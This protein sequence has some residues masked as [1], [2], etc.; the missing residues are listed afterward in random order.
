MFYLECSIDVSLSC[1]ICKVCKLSVI[2]FN[3]L[4]ILSLKCLLCLISSKKASL[5]IFKLGQIS[6]IFLNNSP[7]FHISHIH[8]AVPFPGLKRQCILG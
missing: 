6:Y 1:V 4:M 2:V 8:N 7:G 5:D 3:V